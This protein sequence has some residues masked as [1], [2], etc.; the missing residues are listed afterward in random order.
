MAEILGLGLTHSPSFI[1]P[2]EDGES[3]LKRTLRTN[4]NVPAEMKN[5]SNWPAPT[6]DAA[7]PDVKA[8]WSHH[9]KAV[10][11]VLVLQPQIGVIVWDDN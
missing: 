6:K 10:V 3:S 4:D 7:P 2:D 1:R 8:G 11:V 5:P 9:P